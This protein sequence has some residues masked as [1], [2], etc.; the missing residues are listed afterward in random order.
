M[1]RLDFRAAPQAA[2]KETEGEGGVPLQLVL[3]RLEDA[4]QPTRILRQR[5]KEAYR[6]GVVHLFMHECMWMR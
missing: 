4:L 2:V 6:S 5:W 1:E 3:T